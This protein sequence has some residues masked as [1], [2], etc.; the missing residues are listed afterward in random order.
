MT[1]ETIVNRLHTVGK[2]AVEQR[3]VCSKCFAWLEGGDRYCW[4]CGVGLA[5]TAY[6]RED[7]EGGKE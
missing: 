7:L 4:S 5:E 2:N 6:S 3:D 1:D